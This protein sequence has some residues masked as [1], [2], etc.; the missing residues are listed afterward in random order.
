MSCYRVCDRMTKTS[1]EWKP[2]AKKAII[3]LAILKTI[4]TGLQNVLNL[5][6]DPK[7]SYEG[8]V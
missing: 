8:A 7:A 2:I 5:L 6:D 3:D 1:K 4:D